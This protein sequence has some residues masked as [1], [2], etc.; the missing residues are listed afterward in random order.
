MGDR[1]D[2]IARATHRRGRDGRG[3]EQGMPSSR[4]PRGINRIAFSSEESGK[5]APMPA[6]L[7]GGRV[8]AV[9]P[10][11]HDVGSINRQQTPAMEQASRGEHY[12]GAASTPFEN[13][14][15]HAGI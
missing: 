3:R 13:Y 11:S 15:G 1:L 8:D 5:Q 2:V 14:R 7:Q 4:D 12:Y 9:G 10:T 6:L